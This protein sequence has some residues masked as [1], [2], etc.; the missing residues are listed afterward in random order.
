[1]TKMNMMAGFP[2]IAMANENFANEYSGIFWL[3][4]I[5]ISLYIPC[6]GH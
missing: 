1:M 4:D 5:A 6:R 2:T 3:M